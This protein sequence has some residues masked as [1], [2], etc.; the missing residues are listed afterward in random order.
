MRLLLALLLAAAAAPAGAQV[1]VGA[2][3]SP[4]DFGWA[5]TDIPDTA[6]EEAFVWA[7]SAEVGTAAFRGVFASSAPESEAVRWL[8]TGVY[9][10]EFLA[11][12]LLSDGGRLPFG[13]LARELNRKGGTLSAVARA[14]KAD[15]AGLFAEAGLLK[16]LVDARLP[17]FL[18]AARPAVSTGA[19]AP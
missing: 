1:M 14:R 5:E 13:E 15:L 2:E 18:P 16:V 11:L 3:L 6:S 17:L 10:Q 8:R 4:G 9:R 19:A 12:Y 7:F